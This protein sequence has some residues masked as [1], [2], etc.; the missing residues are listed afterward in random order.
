VAYLHYDVYVYAHC[1]YALIYD[2]HE[3]V[4]VHT[5]IYIVIIIIIIILRR[6]CLYAFVCVCVDV[7]FR[8]AVEFAIRRGDIIIKTAI[9]E[10]DTR[11]LLIKKYIYIYIY[12]KK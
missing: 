7:F 11:R 6:P 1:V 4:Y 2:V 3:Y 10:D 8:R 12:E 5:Y 9:A